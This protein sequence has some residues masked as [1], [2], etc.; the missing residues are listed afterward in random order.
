MDKNTGI[1]CKKTGGKAFSPY[2]IV[3]KLHGDKAEKRREE[4]KGRSGDF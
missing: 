3:G 1:F 4:E 2:F